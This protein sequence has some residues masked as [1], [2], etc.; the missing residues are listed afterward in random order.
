MNITSPIRRTILTLGAISLMAVPAFAQTSAAATSGAAAPTTSTTAKSGR[1]T[2]AQ[3]LQ[4]L[5]ARGDQEVTTRIDSLNKLISRIQG[6]KNVSDT[7][8]NSI[9][10]TIQGLITDM[11]TLKT[12]IDSDNASST[13]KSDVQSITKDYRIYALAIPQLNILAASDRI[14]TIVGMMEQISTK[15][16]LRL[17]SAT[18]VPNISALQSSLNDLNSKV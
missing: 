14:V 11:N 18:G 8:K 5:G 6:L 16:T 10:S 9:V 15:L 12:N 13:M 4:A 7:Q 3:R 2:P 17:Q 1:L